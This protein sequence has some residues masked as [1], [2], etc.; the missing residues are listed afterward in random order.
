MST[1]EI[2]VLTDD[3]AVSPQVAPEDMA[4]IRARGYSTVICNRPDMENP[5]DLHVAAMAAAAEAAGL[6]FVENP[7]AAGLDLSIIDRQ[8][9]AIDAASGP[10]LAY[11]RSGTRSATVWALAEAGRRP[12]DEILRATASAGYPMEGLRP[13]IDGLA[14]RT[15]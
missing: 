15:G 9:A 5:P 1:L 2:R 13:Q 7:F 12:T 10:V 11:C 8:R 14:R 3:Y 4:E 6:T